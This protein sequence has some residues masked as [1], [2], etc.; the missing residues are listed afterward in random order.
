MRI[1]ALGLVVLMIIGA[2]LS[3]KVEDVKIEI[4][5]SSWRQNVVHQ[6]HLDIFDRM[7]EGAVI[8]VLALTYL[9]REAVAELGLILV[10]VI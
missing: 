7:R 3:F 5:R 2:P 10:F 9:V 8:S 1:N 4:Y 6:P